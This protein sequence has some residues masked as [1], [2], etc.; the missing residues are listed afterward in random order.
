MFNDLRKGIIV[1]NIQFILVLVMF[2][3]LSPFHHAV[4]AESVTL[5][6]A[7]EW[8][9]NFRGWYYWPDHVVSP[10]PGID[11]YEKVHMTDVPTVFQIP[12]RD[13]WF[14]T[15]IGFERHR[16]PVV[17]RRERRS[18]TLEKLPSRYGIRP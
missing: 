18:F 16:L 6:Q 7:R 9:E 2:I 14:M 10:S 13:G 5:D 11:G 12:G 1:K 3:G 4:K 17:C 15:F 8:S